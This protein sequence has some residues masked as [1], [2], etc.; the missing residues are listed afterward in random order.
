MPTLDHAF[1]A[2]RSAMI[3]HFGAA[4]DDFEGLAPFDA[5]VAVVLKRA[6]GGER[7]RAAL[8]ALGDDDLLTP[9]RLADAELLEIADAL[10]G[11]GIAATVKTIAPLKHLARWVVEHRDTGIFA[12]AEDDS[13]KVPLRLG[14]L[15][16]ELGAIKGIGPATADAIVLFALKRPSYP[17]DRASFRV[18]VRHGWLDSTASYDE[19]RD[20]LV[21]RAMH[22]A[23][24]L[25]EQAAAT[26]IDLS[27]EM[28]RLGRQFCR[29][30]APHCGGCPLEHLLPEGG[31]REV[32]A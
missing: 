2:V 22:G 26:L 24:E 32:D 28:D 15:L 1:E 23:D 7:G 11:K 31:P 21:D 20:L 4:A 3:G 19:A 10:R 16:E 27:R 5:M 25:E 17:V 13:E 6:L 30:A 18:L 9:E 12:T 29:A 8:D 14:W